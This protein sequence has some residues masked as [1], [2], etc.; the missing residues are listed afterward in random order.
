MANDE[1]TG[2]PSLVTT[3]GEGGFWLVSQ[4]ARVLNTLLDHERRGVVAHK[5]DV[6]PLWKNTPEKGGNDCRAYYLRSKNAIEVVW[7]DG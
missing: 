2:S 1:Q 4:A 3:P 7:G 6:V 5:G